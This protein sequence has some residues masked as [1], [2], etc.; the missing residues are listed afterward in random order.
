MKIEFL[1]YQACGND[2]IYIDCLSGFEYPYGELAKLLSDRHFGVGSDGVIYIC[3]SLF[4]DCKMQ[5][6]NADGSMG[7]MCG[8]AIRAVATYMVKN[9]QRE[10]NLLIETA[11]GTKRVV[12]NVEQNT[13]T[14]N[15]GKASLNP[16]DIG[17]N[18]AEP[19]INKPLI[20]DQAVYPA[21]AV[22]MGNPHCVIKGIPDNFCDV[23]YKINNSGLFSRGANVEFFQ[24]LN[25]EIYVK[26]YERG[27]GRTLS[28]GTGACAVAYSL[29]INEII[30][31][32]IWV[33]LNM[34]GGKLAVM[35]SDD[36]SIYLKGGVNFVFKG[37]IEV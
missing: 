31:K 34:E 21:T 1:K 3:K 10:S 20:I 5:M 17:L 28:C 16:L 2:Y 26:V 32:N 27:S 12:V 30:E 24:I 14:V 25:D 11:S 9:K 6:Y 15:M 35:I 13:A 19:L 23:A 29:L 18:S 37:E 33:T 4:A 7:L 8:N 36:L 22:S